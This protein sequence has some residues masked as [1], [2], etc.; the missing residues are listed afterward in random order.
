MTLKLRQSTASQ[1]VPLGYFVD[2]ADG[3]TEE[4]SLSI[5]NTDIKLWKMGATS[6]ANKNSGGATHISNGLY[7]TVLDATDTG[8]LGSLVIF[9]HVSGA[10][11]VR[12][13]C[14][15]LTANIYDSWIAGSDTFDVQVTGIGAGAITAAAIATDA[16]DA[17]ALADNAITAATFAA[18]AIT[19]AK[20][21]SDV[22]IASVTGA[23]GS[24]TGNVGGNVTGS[25]GSVAS[26]GITATSIAADAIGASELATDAVTEIV[27]AVWAKAMS[28][29]TSVP[30]VSGT[31][32]QALSHVFMMMRNKREQDASDETI[33]QDDG[34]TV[35]ATSTKSDD[36]TTTTI[37]EVT[38][39]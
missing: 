22:T 21:A 12:L 25:V 15:V 13:E 30:A 23:V 8:T 33:Y 36:G 34:S 24:V 1:E 4:T 26:G 6:L 27:D 39:A 19:D 17:D 3:N 9:V 32:L 2:S 37:G 16:I 31:T 35:Y 20:V 18:D 10:L 29:L 11:P 5:A 28:E 7:Y 14:E 38:T